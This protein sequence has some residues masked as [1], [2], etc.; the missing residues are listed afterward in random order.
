MTTGSSS[1]RPA[2][3][4]T[5]SDL[6]GAEPLL[7]SLINTARSGA[8]EISIE[9]FIR[10]SPRAGR[11]YAQVGGTVAHFHPLG[12][13]CMWL[14]ADPAGAL[15]L[16]ETSLD[17]CNPQGAP[18]AASSDGA[19]FSW[20]PA[21]LAKADELARRI[22]DELID[23]LVAV[24][25]NSDEQPTVE[26]VAAVLPGIRIVGESTGAFAIALEIDGH[27]VSVAS[28]GQS[29]TCYVATADISAN[30]TVR[31]G[32]GSPCTAAAA[33]DAAEPAW[34]PAEAD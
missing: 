17:D 9:D 32:T 7:T 4:V 23:H 18:T 10:A 2:Q 21:A 30:T 8:S 33:R 22:V 19:G 16:G 34:P 27:R 25:I 5:A 11:G 13:R 24:I 26:S 20:A 1:S 29:G 14:I 3:E 6:R 15:L 31:Y 28:L 12:D